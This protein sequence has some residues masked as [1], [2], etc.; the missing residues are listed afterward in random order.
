MAGNLDGA[1]DVAF[2]PFNPM[3]AGVDIGSFIM[4]PGGGQVFFV[5]GNGTT[6]TGYDYD[7]PGLADKLVPSVSK[8]LT[9]CVSGRGDTIYVLEGHT[10]SLGSATAWVL[11]SGVKIIGRGFGVQRPIFTLSATASTLTMNVANVIIANCQFYAAGPHGT[12]ALTVTTGFTVTAAGCVLFKNDIECGVDADQLCT[13]LVSWSAAAD[14]FQLLGNN[15]HGG[16]G[17][18]VTNIGVTTG[19]V[20]RLKIAGNRIAAE[21]ATAATGVV[22]DLSNA[23]IVENDIQDNMIAN[24]T[25]SSKY[26]IKPH[27]T[28]TGLVDGN[29]YFTGDGGTAPAS[30]AWTTLTTTYQFGLNYCVTTTGVS[31]ILCPAADA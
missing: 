13:T 10:E 15:I 25:A 11:K 9:Y 4:A 8:A 23:A 20:D 7:P 30:S 14:D 1:H 6:V 2:L 22:F 21:I 28:S 18:V 19:A 26:V 3:P 16:A 24:K 27:A 12:T 5:R 29:R 31:A 17:S